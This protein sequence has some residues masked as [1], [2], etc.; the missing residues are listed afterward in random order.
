MKAACKYS[1]SDSGPNPRR[2]RMSAA[3]VAVV[4]CPLLLASVLA[5]PSGGSEAG[6]PVIPP[7]QEE[8]LLDVLGRGKD[9]ADCQLTDGQIIYT[10]VTATYMCPGGEVVVEIA[11]RSKGGNTSTPTEHFAITLQSG[12]PPRSFIDALV[13]QVRSR[14]SEFEWM[15]LPPAGPDDAL[16]N[17]RP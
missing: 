3:A 6:E 4:A 11:H 10:S 12:A 15:W 1:A 17:S 8:I 13:S 2:P 9:L 7:G 14:E 5:P 16:A